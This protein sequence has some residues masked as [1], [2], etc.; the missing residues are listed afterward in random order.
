M[1][2]ANESKAIHPTGEQSSEPLEYP[3]PHCVETLGGPMQVRWEEDPG[4]SPH[5][6]PTYF[7]EFLHVS[8]I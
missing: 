6:M 3:A 4:I 1:S 7:L 8:G 5:G 2:E